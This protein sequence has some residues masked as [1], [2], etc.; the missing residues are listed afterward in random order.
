M[1][2]KFRSPLFPCFEKQE[3]QMFR[4]SIFTILAGF[5]HS[6]LSYIINLSEC[7]GDFMPLYNRMVTQLPA[8]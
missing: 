6:H 3:E 5:P 4:K 7:L 8:F 1:L 2:D